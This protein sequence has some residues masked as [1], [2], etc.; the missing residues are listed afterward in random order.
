MD[1]ALCLTPAIG[2]TNGNFLQ[3]YF[4]VTYGLAPLQDIRFRNLS[5]P[6]FDLSRSIK[7]MCD[8]IM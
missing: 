6:E 8:I 4:I 7:V 1:L 5:D 2:V 3:P